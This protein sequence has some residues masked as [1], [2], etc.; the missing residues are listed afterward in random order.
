MIDYNLIFIPV[1]TAIVY[2][3]LIF[4]KKNIDVQNPQAFDVVKFAATVL[5]GLVLGLVSVWF[6][7]PVT[8]AGMEAAFLTYGGAIVL[9]ET[10]LKSVYR[11]Y[12][13]PE[14]P[15]GV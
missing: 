9:V 11:W 15:G 13:N 12:F 4:A 5:I 6:N 8:Q 7:L 3:V 10:V 14:L 1:I 2:S